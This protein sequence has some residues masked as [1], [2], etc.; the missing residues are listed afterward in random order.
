MTNVARKTPKK[1]AKRGRTAEKQPV[2]PAPA[3]PPKPE[4][5]RPFVNFDGTPNPDAP[6]SVLLGAMFTHDGLPDG[7]PPS[8]NFLAS[9]LIA[10][11]DEAELAGDVDETLDHSPMIRRVLGRLENRARLAVEIA[12]RIELG[13]VTL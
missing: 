2:Q 5:V 13:E 8:A 7:L 9:V 6:L 11:A 10:A 12:R 3:T 4:P 1:I